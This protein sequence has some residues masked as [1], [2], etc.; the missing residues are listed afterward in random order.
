M[1]DI[2]TAA[3]ATLAAIGSL[4][5]WKRSRLAFIRAIRDVVTEA[6]MS[7]SDS[8]Y[9]DRDSSSEIAKRTVSLTSSAVVLAWA[10][11]FPVSLTGP[12]AARSTGH[13]TAIIAVL[14]FGPIFESP[15]H[16]LNR[17]ARRFRQ[18]F[19]HPMG[20]VRELIVAPIAEEIIFRH[21]LLTILSQRSPQSRICISAV[22][23][24]LAHVHLIANIAVE[25]CRVDV[26]DLTQKYG[27]D[28]V[29]NILSSEEK[30]I[31][32]SANAWSAAKR[33]TG[34]QVTIVFLYGLLCGWVYEKCCE[35]SVVAAVIGHSLCNFTGVPTF[36]FLRR[37]RGGQNIKMSFGHRM[38]SGAA[39][40]AGVVGAIALA[41]A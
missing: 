2:A 17:V 34:A 19:G 18:L 6:Q 13:M 23:F 39:H 10:V 41:W 29:A 4:Y 38:I 36:L 1:K 20:G 32:L 21:A 40:V 35:R 15:Q 33:Q 26:S 31:E 5:L 12:G 24:A 30:R 22:L 27:V 25:A 16:F 14:W 7:T 8:L 37:N 3:A 11:G 28:S 9:F